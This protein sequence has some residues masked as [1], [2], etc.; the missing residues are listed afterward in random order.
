MQILGTGEPLMAKLCIVCHSLSC[1]PKVWC[2][3]VW[4]SPLP[5]VFKSSCLSSKLP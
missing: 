1:N 3:M 5:L 4:F 2:W